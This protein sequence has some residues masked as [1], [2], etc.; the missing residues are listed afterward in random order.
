MAHIIACSSS[1]TS[2]S[3]S[4]Q[5]LLTGGLGGLEFLGFEL[6]NPLYQAA[7]KV[8]FECKVIGT[9]DTA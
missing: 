8:L 5:Q 9:D 7:K 6:L 2:T 4:V 1:S 3:G